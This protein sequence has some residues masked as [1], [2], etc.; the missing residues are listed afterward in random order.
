[1]GDDDRQ[2][3]LDTHRGR[4]AAAR[5]L[6]QRHAAR[7]LAHAA[8][9]VGPGDADD[10]VQSVL[11]GLLALPRRRVSEVQDVPAFLARSTRSAALNHVRSRRREGNRRRAAA[12]C[13]PAPAACGPGIAEAPDEALQRTIDALPRRLREV[14]V[15]KHVAGLTFDQIALA[16]ALN[17]NTAA[18]RYRAAVA[19]LQHALADAA[20]P[21]AAGGPART[22]NTGVCHV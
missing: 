11:C 6:W 1:M 10:V 18:A 19:R 8:A 20:P 15:L 3:L 9:I 4:E 22:M 21:E 2:L 14:V 17:R 5:L 7:L 12:L 13:S 16:L